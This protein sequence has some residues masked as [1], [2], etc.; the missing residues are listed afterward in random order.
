MRILHSRIYR[1]G[2]GV[3]PRQSRPDRRGDRRSPRRKPL[4]VHRLPR[5]SQGRASG[6]RGLQHLIGELGG[7]DVEVASRPV[8]TIAGRLYPRECATHVLERPCSIALVGR[9]IR[10]VLQARRTRVGRRG[11]SPVG[12]DRLA[13]H[14]TTRIAA[15]RHGSATNSQERI[16]H[17]DDARRNRVRGGPASRA[18]EDLGDRWPR[19]RRRS[20]PAS[21]KFWLPILGPSTTWLLRHLAVHL[22]VCPDRGCARCLEHRSSPSA[23]VSRTGKHAPFMRTVTRAIDFRGWPV[24]LDQ[25]A[26][27]YGAFLPA[28][29]ARRHLLRL[30]ESLRR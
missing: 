16:D 1:L 19:S 21:R 3:P 12:E 13:A 9:W 17:D 5:D 11:G 18:V 27:K 26:S 15:I 23:S 8:R 22:D 30:P 25:A 6:S 14:C 20:N 28:P 10:C 7:P 24:W 29:L 2:D 4:P